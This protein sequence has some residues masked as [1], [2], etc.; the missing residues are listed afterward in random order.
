LA[1][2]GLTRGFPDAIASAD[3]RTVRDRLFLIPLAATP[4]AVLLV[5]VALAAPAVAQA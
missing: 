4:L 2:R 3:Q 1:V 5:L